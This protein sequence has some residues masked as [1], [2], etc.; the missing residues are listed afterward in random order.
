M[1]D[2]LSYILGEHAKVTKKGDSI[3]GKFNDI[4]MNRSLIVSEEASFH[5]NTNSKNQFK[6]L[7]TSHTM[8]IEKKGISQFQTRNCLN[9]ILYTNEY[10]VITIDK[11]SRRYLTIKVS[12]KMKG[13][14][15][16]FRPLVEMKFS[17]KAQGAHQ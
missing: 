9:F 8:T 11:G 10:H 16:Y 2:I 13:N 3:T 5:G 14:D 1:T 17:P 15:D 7:I 12:D 6:H 4:L